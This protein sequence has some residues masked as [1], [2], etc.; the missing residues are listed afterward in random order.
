MED[1]YLHQSLD[2]QSNIRLIKLLPELVQGCIACGI[3]QFDASAA[4][5]V[6]YHALSYYW[7][8]PTP[9]RIIAITDLELSSKRH[10]YHLHENLWRFLHRAWE[11][12]LFDHWFWTDSL[13]L[14]Q[15]NTH[16]I[17]RQVPRMGEIYSAAEEVIIWLGDEQQDVGT[18][19]AFQRWDELVLSR[20]R[21]EHEDEWRNALKETAK[22]CRT[23]TDRILSLEYWTR[24]WIVQ[25]V[26]LAAKAR[27]MCGSVSLSLDE[28]QSKAR[29]HHWQ[30]YDSTN[31]KSH[32]QEIVWAL[33]EMNKT[34]RVMPLWKILVHFKACQSTRP[35]DKIYGFFGLIAPNPDGSNPIDYIE[36]DYTRSFSD[37]FFN[38]AFECHTPMEKLKNVMDTLQ[39]LLLKPQ[40]RPTLSGLQ[41]YY[42]RPSTTSPRHKTLAKI[43]LD[44]LLAVHHLVRVTKL[45]EGVL[46]DNANRSSHYT[47]DQRVD[48][49]GIPYDLRGDCIWL[50]LLGLPDVIPTTTLA[51]NAALVACTLLLE[52]D[53][54][55]RWFANGIN[56]MKKGIV[57]EMRLTQTRR[58]S[59]WRC[60]AHQQ[61]WKPTKHRE[62]HR[63]PWIRLFFHPALT[64]LSHVFIEKLCSSR[65]GTPCGGS[66]LVF[67]VPDVEFSF[68]IV[69]GE[70]KNG[71]DIG[72]VYIELA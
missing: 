25:E 44:T 9:T 39:H 37:L 20:D 21:A 69:E 15:R 22:S 5:N 61:R 36:V 48:G 41:K 26:V 59:S 17:Q 43:A 42:S 72:K 32:H 28:F 12:Q 11:L 57:R 66:F 64:H 24:V 23:G 31:L 49:T 34:G 19:R 16:E 45:L 13:C 65:S 54:E 71:L 6:R 35:A 46:Y 18:L 58:A 29:L 1:C 2:D 56:M 62:L 51:Q 50:G 47:Y 52:I 33:W 38:V 67:E 70:D 3:Q 8:D 53:F 30:W 10:R 7:G 27:V 63:C 60:A 14:D 40:E 68:F 4:Q 55:T